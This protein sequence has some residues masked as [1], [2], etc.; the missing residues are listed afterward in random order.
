MATTK[1]FDKKAVITAAKAGTLTGAPL[2]AAIRRAGDLGLTDVEKELKM[3]VVSGSSFAG[4]L[5]PEE[6]RDR[7]AQGVSA[8]TALGFPLSRTKQM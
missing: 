8:L 6:V 5:A 4:D 3:Y 1:T 7:V 2:R